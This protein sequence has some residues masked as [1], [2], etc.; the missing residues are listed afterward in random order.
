MQKKVRGDHTASFFIFAKPVARSTSLDMTTVFH[1]R[2]YGTF[3]EIQ[4]NLR[5]TQIHRTNQG[6]N[7]LGGSFSNRDNVRAPIQFRTE[8][9]PQHLKSWFFL[10]N[11]SIHF[12]INSTSVIRSVKQF[13]FPALKSTDDFLPQSTVSGRSNLILAAIS[14]YCYRSDTWSD[15]QSRE[16]S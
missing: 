8:R 15:L 11:G 13:F 6:S 4:T 2:L 10:K 9:Q 16:Y 1:A 12:H 3:V 5:R 7:F 14:V